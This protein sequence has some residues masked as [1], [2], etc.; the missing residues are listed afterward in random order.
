LILKK[1]K[2]KSPKSNFKFF[3]NWVL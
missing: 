1:S 2:L 3:F